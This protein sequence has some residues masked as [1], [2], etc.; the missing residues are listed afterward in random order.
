VPLPFRRQHVS[1]ESPRRQLRPVAN[2]ILKTHLA[3][4]RAI[5]RKHAQL[6]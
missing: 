4:V 2:I 6:R 5:T 1:G 3:L